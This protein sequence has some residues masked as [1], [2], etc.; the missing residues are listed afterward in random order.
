M[1]EIVRHYP[2]DSLPADLRS[3]FPANGT[4]KIE[5]EPVAT[6][7]ERVLLAPLAGTAPNIHGDEEDILRHIRDLRED[8]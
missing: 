8:R 7:T 1:N 3:R 4:V 5:L 2:V 6:A